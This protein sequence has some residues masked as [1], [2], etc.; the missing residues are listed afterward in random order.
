MRP[1]PLICGPTASGKTDLALA[2]AERLGTAEIVS[3]DAFHIYR[4]MDIGTAKPSPEQRRRVPHHL[5]DLREPT[6][7]FS[8]EQWL[9]LAEAA[10]E[11]VRERGATP[12]VVGGTHLYVKALLD[13]LF[14]SPSPDPDL[15]ARLQV[16][17]PSALRAELER[18]DP[19]AAARIHP[20]DLRRTIRALEVHR[21][22]GRPISEHQRQWDRAGRCDA[23]LVIL[24]WDP[25]EL[26]QRINARVRAMVQR[27][28]VEEVRG[29]WE[30][31]RLGEQAREA[32][33]YKQLIPYFEGQTTLE[34]AIER[35]KI[36]SRRLA[37][38]Q[39]T[40][41][42]RILAGLRESSGPDPM[43]LRA[44]G[45]SPVEIAQDIAVQSFNAQ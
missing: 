40:W 19:E 7:S 1:F 15:R 13:G 34:D 24:G 21:A 10:I 11:G 38:N 23:Q 43:V 41:I 45:R 2:L 31:G 20:N 36:E 30:S 12:I 39:R 8:V 18:V 6:E 25:Q 5:V 4:G 16:M 26:N 33:G 14:H 3:A 29:L 42:R 37:K 32:I 44:E 28:L 22:T 17:D 27:G 9:R 35:M